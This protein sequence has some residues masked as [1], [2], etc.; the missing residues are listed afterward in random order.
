[1]VYDA[2]GSTWP[3]NTGV[4]VQDGAAY[5][6]A[7]IIDCDG[8]YVF[9]LDAATGKIKWQNNSSGHLNPGIRKGVSA[10]GTMTVLGDRVLMAG[11]NQVCPASYDAKT[12][13]CLVG[14]PGNGLPKANRGQEVGVF[15]ANALLCFAFRDAPAQQLGRRRGREAPGTYGQD[16]D[17]RE[18]QDVRPQCQQC[19]S[20]INAL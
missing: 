20:P 11:G 6:A 9:A 14:P 10:Q 17:R 4:L 1:M 3:V 16:A 15:R 18:A 8:T 2:L 19:T 13:K 12:G 5:L 7:G